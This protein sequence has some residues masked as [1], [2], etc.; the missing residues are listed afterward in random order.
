MMIE[1]YTKTFLINLMYNIW[2][3]LT[4]F[5]KN[6]HVFN[7]KAFY[8]LKKLLTINQMTEGM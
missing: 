4:W 3:S 1:R 6:V 5:L 2:Y 7:K 8:L